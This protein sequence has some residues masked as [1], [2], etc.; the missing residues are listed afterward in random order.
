MAQTTAEEYVIEAIRKC[1]QIGGRISVT[2]ESVVPP[3]ELKTV[4]V[5]IKP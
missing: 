1:V 3:Y 5:E 2:T 4:S